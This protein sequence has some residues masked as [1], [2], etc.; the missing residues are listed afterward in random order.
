MSHP[1]AILRRQVGWAGGTAAAATIGA[2]AVGIQLQ[3]AFDHNALADVAQ[4]VGD[5][6][7]GRVTPEHV[8]HVDAGEA[9]ACH[10]CKVPV[11]LE[12]TLVRIFDEIK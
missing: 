3:R 5:R 7:G 12:V 4:G 10:V 1:T 8:T 9:I 6:A 11:G 2:R